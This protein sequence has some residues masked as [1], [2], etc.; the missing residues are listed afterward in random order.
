MTRLSPQ[1]RNVIL[2]LSA[3]A[4]VLGYE[5][6]TWG[7]LEGFAMATHAGGC[8]TAS[9]GIQ[10]FCD[11]V[12]FYLPQGE[13]LA[14]G[15]GRVHGFLYPPPFGLF[16]RVLTALGE[17]SALRVWVGIVALSML[18]LFALPAAAL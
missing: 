9:G 14:L 2:A 15:H 8:R 16:M 17:P 3:L 1:R 5:V 11:A 18:A 6:W 10:L 4:L 13:A 7:S 12:R